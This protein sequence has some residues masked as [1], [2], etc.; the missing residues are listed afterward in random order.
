[1]A[2]NGRH[3]P[4]VCH[5]RATAIYG[6]PLQKARMNVTATE[7]AASVRRIRRWSRMNAAK[8][9]SLPVIVHL[10]RHFSTLALYLSRVSFDAAGEAPVW[11]DGCCLQICK[12][13]QALI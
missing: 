7:D 5:L 2:T 8:W 10:C 6:V 12:F 4:A 11:L 13:P 1:M 9:L 3:K